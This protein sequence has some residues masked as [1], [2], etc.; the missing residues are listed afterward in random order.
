MLNSGTF[1]FLASSFRNN[2]I[3]WV[4]AVLIIEFSCTKF[5]HIGHQDSFNCIALPNQTNIM[6]VVCEA[7]HISSKYCVHCS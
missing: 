3:H 6:K 1:K 4:Q 2:F 5:V 7:T